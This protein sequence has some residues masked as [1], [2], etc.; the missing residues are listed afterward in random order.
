MRIFLTLLLIIIWT[1]LILAPLEV[2]AED[3]IY[4]CDA[5]VAGFPQK[6]GKFYIEVEYQQETSPILNSL[7]ESQI[8]LKDESVL[9]KNNSNRKFEILVPVERLSITK[10]FQEIEEGLKSWDK[11]LSTDSFKIFYFKYVTDDGKSS[12]KRISINES[13]TRTSEITIPDDNYPPYFFL[14]KCKKK[15]TKEPIQIEY[16]EDPKK[17]VS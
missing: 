13:Y 2:F 7:T 12:L 4:T 16:D 14:R 10:S 11:M 1:F 5:V 3:E 8:L 9:Y 17:K 6:D 15:I